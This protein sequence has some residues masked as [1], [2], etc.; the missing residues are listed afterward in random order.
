MCIRDSSYVI[1]LIPAVIVGLVLG[2]IYIAITRSMDAAISRR[3]AWVVAIL[4]IVAM[5]AIP[6]INP[7]PV[8]EAGTGQLLRAIMVILTALVPTFTFT[9][10]T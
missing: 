9:S 7:Y 6:V 2:A 4:A 8:D 1:N 10:N 3:I 5:L